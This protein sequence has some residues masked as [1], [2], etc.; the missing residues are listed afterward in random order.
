MSARYHVN[1]KPGDPGLCS[2]QGGNFPFGGWEDHSS[3][4]EG[5]RAVYEAKM[6]SPFV[7]SNKSLAEEKLESIGISPDLE[8]K[9]AQAVLM[10]SRDAVEEELKKLPVYVGDE[11]G[12]GDQVRVTRRAYD[13]KGRL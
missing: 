2:A 7:F 11:P 13:A 10:L 9:A 8:A 6:G 4:L 5:T 12:T 3:S 1:P